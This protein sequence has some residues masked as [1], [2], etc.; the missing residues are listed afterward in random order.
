[1]LDGPTV[2]LFTLILC[3]THPYYPQLMATTPSTRSAKL[4]RLPF[5]L[6][7]FLFLLSAFD[8]FQQ[9]KFGL[10]VVFLL[11]SLLNFLSLRYI[12]SHP[13]RTSIG[14]NLLN[15]IGAFLVGWNYWQGGSQ[16]I[17]YVWFLAAFL[18]VIAAA[19][20]WRKNR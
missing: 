7:A 20:G 10:A 2:K 11:I 15:V 13:L 6:G 18:Y 4:V 9:S 17:H 19:L 3:N 1:M 8:F 14:V 12:K 16:S 5:I